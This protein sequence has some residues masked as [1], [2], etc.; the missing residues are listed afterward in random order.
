M[1]VPVA[2]MTSVVAAPHPM[3][4]QEAGHLAVAVVALVADTVKVVLLEVS[5]RVALV[6]DTVRA[7]LLEVSAKVALVVDIAMVD[8]VRVVLLA[9]S[10]RVAL[11]V[12]GQEIA[13][14]VI[15]HTLMQ[16]PEAVLQWLKWASPLLP[17]ALSPKPV[18]D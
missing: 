8:T 18:N 3:L 13:Q 16:A 9:D 15:I 10:A 7:V 1:S 4:A 6:V 12:K 5:A 11:E 17:K 2:L 14:T